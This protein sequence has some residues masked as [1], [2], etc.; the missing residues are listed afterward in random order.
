MFPRN[1][2]LIGQAFAE[3]ALPRSIGFAKQ[4]YPSQSIARAVSPDG[5]PT[6]R[7]SPSQTSRLGPPRAGPDPSHR[8]LA[9]PRA[10]QHFS[11]S[12]AGAGRYACLTRN[13]PRGRALCEFQLSSLPLRQPQP[14][15]VASTHPKNVP[16]AAQSRGPFWL[17]R[18]TTACL[19][20]QHLAR[21][22]A[23]LA[24]GSR[25]CPAATER[26]RLTAGACVST[27]ATPANSWGGLLCF[28]GAPVAQGGRCFA[29][30]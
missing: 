28:M 24:A 7:I 5:T 12:L 10:G 2:L 18:Q 14:L 30:S 19:Q 25:A 13:P 4:A 1:P 29:R 15:R 8:P 26:A 27:K 3:A 6:S 22:A 21:R 11:F 23:R 16:L 20:V 9:E 17:T